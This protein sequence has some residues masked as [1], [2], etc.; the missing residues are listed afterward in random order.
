[1]NI[2]EDQLAEYERRERARTI[3]ECAQIADAH[4]GQARKAREKSG[5]KTPDEALAEI[6]A[7]ERGEDIA[8]E[9]ISNKIRG[10]SK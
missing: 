4:K 7:E 8:A 10:L 3:E 6:W 1:M 9:E 5:Y 2:T